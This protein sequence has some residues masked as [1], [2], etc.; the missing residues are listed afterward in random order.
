MASGRTTVFAYRFDWDEEPR[1]LGT[2]LSRLLGAAHGFELPFLFGTFDLGDP[3]SS[4]AVFPEETRA[5]REL[6]GERMR[7][8]WA[9]F[10]RTGRPGRGGREDLPEWLA[11]SRDESEDAHVLLL[12][13]EGDGG[14]R[15]AR[16]RMTRESVIAAVEAEAG[17]GRDE[18]CAML[19]DLFGDG[20][21]RDAEALLSIRRQGCH[22][23]DATPGPPHAGVSPRAGGLP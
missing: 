9:E 2:D 6:L 10:A 14:I 13:T 22:E 20:D 15:V 16:T 11:W 7:A 18:K 4:R 1:R 12:D 8:Y 5:S 19:L 21:G 23:V 3:V 17:L